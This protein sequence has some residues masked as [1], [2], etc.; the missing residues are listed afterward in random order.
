MWKRGEIA[1]GE[2]FLPFSTIFQYIFLI[3]GVRLHSHLKN[4]VVQ[5]VF[6]LNTTN[7][8][9]RSTDIS[10]CFLGSLR[11]QDNESRLYI[12]R[13]MMLYGEIF[14]LGMVYC[15]HTP[16]VWHIQSTLVISTSVISNNRLSRRESL[17]PVLT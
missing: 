8:I 11:F 10:K 2:Q 5:I 3:K 4:L 12:I 15:S 9:C 6:F 13:T 16:A 1:P 7:S 17:I 14:Y